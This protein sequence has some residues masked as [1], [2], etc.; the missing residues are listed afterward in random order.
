[1]GSAAQ[2]DQNASLGLANTLKHCV[3]LLLRNTLLCKDRKS[4]VQNSVLEDHAFENDFARCLFGALMLTAKLVDYGEDQKWMSDRKSLI[5]CGIVGRDS[6]TEVL[7]PSSSFRPFAPLAGNPWLVET[8]LPQSL[9]QPV[10]V[11]DVLELP[12]TRVQHPACLVL[13]G[14]AMT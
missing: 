1:M 10:H 6:D 4:T 14:H 8:S 7:S 5:P 9:S 3:L 11:A 2:S 13:P 12:S